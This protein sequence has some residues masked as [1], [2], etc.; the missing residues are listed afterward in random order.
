MSEAL[1][2]LSCIALR[3]P[4]AGQIEIGHGLNLRRCDNVREA[5]DVA[6]ALAR[7]KFPA[8]EG[9]SGHA[10]LVAE[11]GEPGVAS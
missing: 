8:A 7:E 9:W 1:Y 4:R 10:A 11:V 3:S 6:L 2:A 5:E